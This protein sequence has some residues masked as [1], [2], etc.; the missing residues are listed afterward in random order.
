MLRK[1]HYFKSGNYA[2]IHK[3]ETYKYYFKI[4][5]AHTNPTQII[6]SQNCITFFWVLQD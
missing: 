2:T 1:Y 5:R 3:K 4:K 6:K